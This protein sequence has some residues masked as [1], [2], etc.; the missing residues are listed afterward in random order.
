MKRIAASLLIVVSL[1]VAASP[2]AAM[3]RNKSPKSC[4]T[5][6]AASRTT[7]AIIADFVEAVA[8]YVDDLRAAA[9]VASNAGGTNAAVAAFLNTQGIL[10]N[11]LNAEAETAGD[12]LEVPVTTFRASAAK[13]ERG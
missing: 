5:A 8:T 3:D 4:L 11:T 7:V 1:A 2:A 10:L 9:Q 13:C 12:L 6:I